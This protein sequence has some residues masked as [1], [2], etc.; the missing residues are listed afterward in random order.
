M[1][2]TAM[3]AAEEFEKRNIDCTVVNMRF[4]KPLDKEMLA[5][6]SKDHNIFFTIEENV[7]FGGLGQQVIDAI[8]ELDKE[9]YVYAAAVEDQFVGHGTVQQQRKRLGLDTDSIVEKLVEL[10]NTR[11][12]G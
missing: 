3:E 5:K 12:R 4:L 1:V 7:R 2:L 8:N 9:I 11:N 10:A 6:L